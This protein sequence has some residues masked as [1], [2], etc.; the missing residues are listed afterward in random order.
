[1][2]KC[3]HCERTFEKGPYER[4]LR[5]KHHTF[6]SEGCFVLYHYKFPKVDMEQMY[7]ETSISVPAD[8]SERIMKEL[9]E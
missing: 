3:E 2:P 5:G 7:R 4:V 1:M 6:C 9:R 8:A